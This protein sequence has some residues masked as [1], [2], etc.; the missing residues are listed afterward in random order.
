MTPPQQAADAGNSDAVE[1]EG[2]APVVETYI[3]CQ[4]FVPTVNNGSEMKCRLESNTDGMILVEDGLAVTWELVNIYA[5]ANL[6]TFQAE[7]DDWHITVRAEAADN[8]QSVYALDVVEITASIDGESFRDLNRQLI[9][10]DCIAGNMGI[11]LSYGPD[12]N[13]VIGAANVVEG[14]GQVYLIKS[15]SQVN[16]DSDGSQLLIEPNAAVAD[17]GEGTYVLALD[18]VNYTGLNGTSKVFYTSKAKVENAGG[19]N[20]PW[21]SQVQLCPPQ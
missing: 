20:Y 1:V 8:L 5:P 7:E 11:D 18:G 9:G 4:Q 12:F 21:A 14:P 6:I 15:Q 13:T 16:I 10:E 3:F 2:Q 19:Q 17:D